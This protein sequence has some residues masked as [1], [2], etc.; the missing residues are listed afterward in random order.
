MAITQD[1]ARKIGAAQL[2]TLL[3]ICNRENKA[4]VF[5]NL[6]ENFQTAG[7][8]YHKIHDFYKHSGLEMPFD[9]NLI[10]GHLEKVLDNEE[11]GVVKRMVS[12]NRPREWALRSEGAELLPAVAFMANFLPQKYQ[13]SAYSVIG[14]MNSVRNKRASYDRI[15]ILLH[16]MEGSLPVSHFA[17]VLGIKAWAV[18]QKLYDLANIEDASGKNVPFVLPEKGKR[19]GGKHI[20]VNTGKELAFEDFVQANRNIRVASPQKIIEILKRQGYFEL[21]PTSEFNRYALT[22]AGRD[23]VKNC[24][25]PSA[26]YLV[27]DE[28]SVEL[29]RSSQPQV[30][31]LL[32]CVEIYTQYFRRISREIQEG[33]RRAKH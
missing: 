27:K 1:Q 2:E 22:D 24:L 18:Y 6:T 29:V 12:K 21:V 3:D 5:W 13:V 33:T 23:Y 8:L 19:A 20:Y 26:G 7:E 10:I 25:I 11:R 14:A 9:Y 32:E 17:D 16:L 4:F 30:Q 15:T 28:E 31:N